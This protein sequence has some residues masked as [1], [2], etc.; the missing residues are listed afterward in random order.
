MR[1]GGATD[2]AICRAPSFG[3]IPVILTDNWVSSFDRTTQWRV[4]G[5]FTAGR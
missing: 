4:I 3:R 1:V 2:N 5:R